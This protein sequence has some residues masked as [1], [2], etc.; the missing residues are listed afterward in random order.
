MEV[1]NLGSCTNTVV[2]TKR[3][4]QTHKHVNVS[5]SQLGDCPFM[6]QQKGHFTSRRWA[7][8]C[9]RSCIT[10][11]SSALFITSISDLQYSAHERNGQQGYQH[12]QPVRT[13]GTLSWLK[14]QCR[15]WCIFANNLIHK[16]SC[17]LGRKSAEDTV[18]ATVDVVAKITPSSAVF[19]TYTLRQMSSRESEQKHR[20]SCQES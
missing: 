15:L 18:H 7:H 20:Y 9:T 10:F 2:R 16:K 5:R 19:R 13:L 3:H 4:P 17:L 8:K 14:P 6:F 1:R 12:E 11:R